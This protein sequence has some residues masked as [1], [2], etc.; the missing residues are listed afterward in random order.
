MPQLVLLKLPLVLLT[1][2]SS[3]M[4]CRLQLPLHTV[5]V[6]MCAGQ[7][8]LQSETLLLKTL[9]VGLQGGLARRVAQGML[10]RASLCSTSE[11]F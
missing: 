11:R 4:L 9:Q 5:A 6:L 8:L 10:M 2:H 7:L 3:L 1:D